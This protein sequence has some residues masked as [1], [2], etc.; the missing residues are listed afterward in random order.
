MLAVVQQD[1]GKIHRLNLSVGLTVSVEAT[2]K[3]DMATV[4]MR[5]L[6]NVGSKV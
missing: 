2:A 4:Y 5:Q 1:T 3:R 6:F